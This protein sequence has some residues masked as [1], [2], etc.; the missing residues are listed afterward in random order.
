MYE[1]EET[2][3]TA[4]PLMDALVAEPDIVYE[5]DAA[6]PGTIVCE[7]GERVHVG[8]GGVHEISTRPPLPEE[9]LPPR[10]PLPPLPYPSPFEL[11][12]PVPPQLRLPFC[13][14]PPLVF[15]VPPLAVPPLP[16]PVPDWPPAP[17]PLPVGPP[18]PKLE[19]VPGEPLIDIYLLPDPPPPPLP[20][21][22]G[23]E[24]PTVS[25]PT[26]YVFCEYPPPPPPPPPTA[27]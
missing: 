9:P 24:D 14:S 19:S 26:L 21:V 16:P 27:L 22:T 25:P 17:P 15:V 5:R 12:P 7:D 18:V 6:L 1:P 8:G 13:P 10:P 23:I 11:V 20:T 3:E 4:T 2:V